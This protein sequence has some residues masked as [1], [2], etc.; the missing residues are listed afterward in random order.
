MSDVLKSA[1][2]KQHLFKD[3]MPSDLSCHQRISFSHLDDLSSRSILGKNMTSILLGSK[4]LL[5]WRKLPSGI[6]VSLA[7]DPVLVCI[8]LIS[9]ILNRM[10]SDQLACPLGYL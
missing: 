3:L 7:A 5:F 6:K 9:N 2:E 1:S 8:D 4:T 10:S